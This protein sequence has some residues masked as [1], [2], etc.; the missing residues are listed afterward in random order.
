M[1][2]IFAGALRGRKLMALPAGV[3]GLRPTAAKVREAIFDRLGPGVVDTRV[4]DLYAGSG[5][6]S[7]EALSRGASSALLVEEDA[8]VVKH[9]QAQL[10]ALGVAARAKVVRSTAERVLA[11]GP[12]SASYDLVFVDP[13]FASPHVFGPIAAALVQHRWLGP[14]ARIVC[15]RERVRGAAPN[16]EYPAALELEAS[17]VYGQ[18]IVEFLQL[19]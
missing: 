19:A 6:L 9:L 11:G 3:A 17:R 16:V 7:I 12:G 14:G 5:A 18:V 13:P 2:R 8:R 10:A 1:Q 4:L 15:E